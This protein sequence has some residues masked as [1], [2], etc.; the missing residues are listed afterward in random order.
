MNLTEAKFWLDVVQWAVTVALAVS[1]WLRKPGT[2]AGKAVEA[3]KQAVGE[4]FDAHRELHAAEM[5]RQGER[6]TEIEA[7][8]EHMPTSEELRVLE[9][10][11][12]QIAER[13]QGMSDRMTGIT[14]TLNRIEHHLLSRGNG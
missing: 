13:T 9:G 3:L 5:R 12:K 2:D 10:T 8:M 7:H 1:V 6:I 11:V 4:R 14:A